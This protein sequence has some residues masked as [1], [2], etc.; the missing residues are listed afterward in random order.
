MQWNDR[1]AE[2]VVLSDLTRVITGTF[3]K[4]RDVHTGTGFAIDRAR[5]APKEN[6]QI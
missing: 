2:K 5:Y 6:S 1:V 4:A 3:S